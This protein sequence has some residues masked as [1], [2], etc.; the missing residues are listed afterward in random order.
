MLPVDAEANAVATLGPA[1]IVRELVGAR[2][3]ILRRVGIISNCQTTEK[4]DLRTAYANAECRIARKSF[5][6][7]LARRKEPVSVIRIRETKIVN[8]IRFQNAGQPKLGLVRVVTR[9]D[10]RR[11]HSRTGDAVIFVYIAANE[12]IVFFIQVIV[13][14]NSDQMLIKG[15]LA[16]MIEPGQQGIG[17]GDRLRANLIAPFIIGEKEEFV[18]DDRSAY[19]PAILSA[20]EEWIFEALASVGI[21]A[22]YAVGGQ[23]RTIA[24]QPGKCRHVVIA[25]EQE[26]AA[27]KVISST[28]RDDVDS[29]GRNGPDREVETDCVDLKLLN[30]FSREI[31]R[32]SAGDSI[33][34]PRP[35]HGNHRHIRRRSA[36][37]DLEKI[38]LIENAGSCLIGHCDSRF[39]PCD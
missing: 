5:T 15:N 25:I 2:M 14:A 33:I 24:R 7:F 4:A 6:F 9:C 22:Q 37:P 39:Q 10:P 17:K 8:Q 27:V 19:C 38:V 35:I 31:L 26:S 29:A 1:E 12:N 18:I 11:F 34:G 36:N 13:Q 28:A 30:C 3:S 20:Y 32:G 16:D 21:A 23:P